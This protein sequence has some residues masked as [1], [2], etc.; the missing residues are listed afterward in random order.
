ML[1]FLND[2]WAWLLV[3]SFII[4]LV[5]SIMKISKR[6]DNDIWEQE[7]ED[8]NIVD[9]DIDWDIGEEDIKKRLN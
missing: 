4:L 7:D 6:N 2:N 8:D 3:A 5:Y 9:M 1:E